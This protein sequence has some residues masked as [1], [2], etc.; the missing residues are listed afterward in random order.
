VPRLLFRL[1]H[2]RVDGRHSVITGDCKFAGSSSSKVCFVTK[3]P[4]NQRVD[5]DSRRCTLR[6]F[7]TSSLIGKETI[8]C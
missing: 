1:E 5:G 8:A 6:I 2:L 7:P 4:P 3:N